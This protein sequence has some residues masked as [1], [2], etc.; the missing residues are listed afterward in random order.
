MQDD[1]FRHVYDESGELQKIIKIDSVPGNGNGDLPTDQ[2]IVYIDPAWE[3]GAKPVIG[4]K[5]PS[6][7]TGQI[8]GWY[9]INEFT[10]GKR[11]NLKLYLEVKDG[12]PGNGTGSYEIY[13]PDALEPKLDWFV[14]HANAWIS[15]GGISEFDGSLKWTFRNQ[16]KGPKLIFT[17]DGTEWDPTHPKQFGNLKIRANISYLL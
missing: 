2:A 5:N 17:F 8:R 15:G 11:V 9:T 7:G 1:F 12:K 16:A 4:G 13:L 6:P 14:G 10:N 3:I